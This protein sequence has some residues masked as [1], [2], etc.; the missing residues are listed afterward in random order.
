[1]RRQLTVYLDDSIP[2]ERMALD[3]ITHSPQ[4]KQDLLR[5]MLISAAAAG[6]HFPAVHMRAIEMPAESAGALDPVVK[7]APVTSPLKEL[8]PA[9]AP[10]PAVQAEPAKEAAKP[11]EVKREKVRPPVADGGSN[12][13]PRYSMIFGDEESGG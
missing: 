10:A 6:R 7:A 5:N 9:P 13:S 1:M 11:V 3:Y 8:E 2:A 4:R 12:G